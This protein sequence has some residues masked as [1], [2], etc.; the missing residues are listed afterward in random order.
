M[1]YSKEKAVEEW[2]TAYLDFLLAFD[3]KFQ[4]TQAM[5]SWARV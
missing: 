2:L 3:G 5:I 4:S 1:H